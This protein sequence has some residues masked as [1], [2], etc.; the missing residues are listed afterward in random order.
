[1]IC[2]CV[3]H[4]SYIQSVYI[5]QSNYHKSKSQTHFTCR[6]LLYGRDVVNNR[7]FTVTEDTGIVNEEICNDK[8]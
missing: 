5:R 3:S 7:H 2:S 6:T 1:M 8:E 4:L